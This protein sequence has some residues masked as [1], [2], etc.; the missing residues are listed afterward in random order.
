MPIAPPLPPSPMITGYHR[1]REFEHLGN[2]RRDRLGNATTL[3]FDTGVG[4]WR[5]DKCYDRHSESFGHVE[6]ASAFR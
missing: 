3:R 6:K 2:A 5:I 4:A 1:Y